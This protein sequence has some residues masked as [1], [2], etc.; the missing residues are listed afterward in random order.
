LDIAPVIP[1]GSQNISK[2]RILSKFL[3]TQNEEI[4]K[5]DG[6]HEIKVDTGKKR[7]LDELP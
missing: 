1:N 3:K 2:K 7:K 4:N 5:I 6:K